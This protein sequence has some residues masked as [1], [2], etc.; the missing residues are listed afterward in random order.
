MRH[1]RRWLTSLR[2]LRAAAAVE[3]S[4]RA[5]FED[6]KRP[7]GLSL[8]SSPNSPLRISCRTGR[9]SQ[10]STQYSLVQGEGCS[11]AFQAK[12]SLAHQLQQQGEE[13][14]Y[15]GWGQFSSGR[16]NASSLC[17]SYRQNPPSPISCRES[18]TVQCSHRSQQ[19]EA[20]MP[21]GMTQDSADTKQYG[22][23]YNEAAAQHYSQGSRR[24]A[25][26]RRGPRTPAG[27]PGPRA[28][29]HR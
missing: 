21:Y 16:R 3:F 23:Q 22:S 19:S 26:R 17:Q 28:W 4:A 2:R 13:E 25:R 12:V 1:L 7:W 27:A 11:A 24:G 29:P 8:S 6:P 20:K 18:S 15:R 14:Q 5:R 9:G 10:N